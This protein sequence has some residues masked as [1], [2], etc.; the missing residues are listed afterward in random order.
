M[1]NFHL[2]IPIIFKGKML[3]KVTCFSLK[4]VYFAQL[5]SDS[6]NLYLC[7]AKLNWYFF[8]WIFLFSLV[9]N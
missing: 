2:Y 4:I 3:L 6:L 5:A 7:E 1:C 9:D 8:H